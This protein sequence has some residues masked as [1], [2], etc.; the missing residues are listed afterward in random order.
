[1][2]AIGQI[3]KS[4]GIR[5]E[6]KI[7]PLTDR[8]QRFQRLQAVWLGPDDKGGTQYGIEA[9][10]IAK[11]HLVLKLKGVDTRSGAD[12]LKAQYVLIPDDEAERGD[13][14]FFIHDLIGMNVRTDT[15]EEIG[16]IEDVVRLPS[17]DTWVV[18]N[19]EKEILIPGVKEFIRS[20]DVKGR[21]VVIHVIEGLVD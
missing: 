15:G 19:G 8:M 7:R 13:G 14:S 12:A 5:G 21:K 18:R 9:L 1:M 3:A 10:R 6:L 20:V 17:G 16:M 4:V 2:I 11:D